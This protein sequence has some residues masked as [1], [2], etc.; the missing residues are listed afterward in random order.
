MKN[1]VKPFFDLFFNKKFS[2]SILS[3]CILLSFAA[4]GSDGDGDDGW[5]AEYS[6]GDTGPGG[7]I[8]FY[9]DPAGFTMADTGEKAYYLEAA[10]AGWYVSTAPNDPMLVWVPTTSVAYIPGVSGTGTAVGT[11]RN[12][13]KLILDADTTASAAKECAEYPG[14]G[15]S[16]WFL[17]SYDELDLMYENLYKKGL[18]GFSDAT[19]WS[20]SQLPPN[21]NGYALNFNNGGQY[22]FFK[23]S[24][25]SVRA[26]RAF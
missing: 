5:T 10:P 17:P 14:G 8:I 11:G 16:D 9:H 1:V 20:S 25:L 21:S 13:T 19:Y 12:N 18:G 15:Q 3:I 2:I 24:T 23:Y 7:G 22:G 6:I 26:I 4:C